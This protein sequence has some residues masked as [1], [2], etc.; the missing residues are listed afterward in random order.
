MAIFLL[1]K[2]CFGTIITRKNPVY[3]TGLTPTSENWQGYLHL[4]RSVSLT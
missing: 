2:P 1:K 3:G 4:S